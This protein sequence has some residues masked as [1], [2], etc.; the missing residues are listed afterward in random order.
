MSV[1]T[2][3]GQVEQATLE[4]QAGTRLAKVRQDCCLDTLASWRHANRREGSL[5]VQLREDRAVTMWAGILVVL[6][7]IELDY[8]VAVWPTRSV[9][10]IAGAMTIDHLNL[11][12]A[13]DIVTAQPFGSITL[14]DRGS[15]DQAFVPQYLAGKLTLPG[16]GFRA[17]PSRRS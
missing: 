6:P 14:P 11:V 13:D 12:Q 8:A 5:A 1:Q 4:G 15:D 9:I 10:A 2:A 3:H 16:V 17:S 7:A